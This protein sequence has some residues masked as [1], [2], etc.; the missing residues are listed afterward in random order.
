[1]EARQR[2]V[3]VEHREEVPADLGQAEVQQAA[4]LLSAGVVNSHSECSRQSS[5]TDGGPFR[6]EPQTVNRPAFLCGG[7]HRHMPLGYLA[8]SGVQLPCAGR[9]A[10]L[11]L[12]PSGIGDHRLDARG[13]MP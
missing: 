6:L 4:A 13:R 3:A 1:M 2:H 10:E 11:T 7:S 8:G 5:R 9:P 12:E